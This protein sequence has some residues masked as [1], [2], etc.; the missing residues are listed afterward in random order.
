MPHS[1]ESPNLV[2][3]GHPNSGVASKKCPTGQ[4][5]PLFRNERRLNVAEWVTCQAGNAGSAADLRLRFPTL[6]RRLPGT[7]HSHG[8]PSLAPIGS[9]LPTCPPARKLNCP[10]RSLQHQRRQGG[11]TA[12]GRSTTRMSTKGSACVSQRYQ[13]INQQHV[14]FSKFLRS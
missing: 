7:P 8:R 10:A 1:C 9:H 3:P 5:K 6:G 2:Y 14:P 4:V 11:F 12:L 13:V